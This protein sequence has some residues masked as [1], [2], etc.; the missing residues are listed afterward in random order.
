MK[1]TI[2]KTI[3]KDD[4]VGKGSL[5]LQKYLQ[6]GIDEIIGPLYHK[7]ES[8]GTVFFSIVPIPLQYVL[9]VSHIRAELYDDTDWVG[10]NR[11]FC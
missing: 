4:E 2:N 11:S 10:K 7:E 6:R 5:D 3:G 9:V 1:F 8:S